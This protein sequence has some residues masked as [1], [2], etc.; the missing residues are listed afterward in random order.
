MSYEIIKKYFPFKLTSFFFSWI[1]ALQADLHVNAMQLLNYQ[2]CN[3]FS[4]K[5][6]NEWT[7]SLNWTNV[8]NS[9]S[10]AAIGIIMV[11]QQPKTRSES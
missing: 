1:G 7:H 9:Y 11:T 8:K 6:E 10:F 2:V 5:M 4:N 3:C